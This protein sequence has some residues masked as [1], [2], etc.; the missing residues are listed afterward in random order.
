MDR[1][2][3]RYSIRRRAGWETF[4]IALSKDSQE[5]LFY[6]CEWCEGV[7]AEEDRVF[8]LL[9]SEGPGC[10]LDVVFCLAIY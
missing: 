2:R 3:D 9:E 6:A 10:G 7:G 4:W 1:F 5:L 8:A